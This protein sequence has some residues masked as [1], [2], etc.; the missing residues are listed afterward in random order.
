MMYRFGELELDTGRRELCR[1]GKPVKLTKLSFKVL[2]VLVESAPDLVTH[3]DLIDRVWGENRVISPENLSQRIKMLRESLGDSADTPTYIEVVRGQGVRLIP[4]VDDGPAVDSDSVSPAAQAQG[5]RQVASRA[6]LGLVAAIVAI[7]AL[8]WFSRESGYQRTPD[9]NVAGDYSSVAVLPFSNLSPDPNNSFFAAGMHEE[10][11]NQLAKLTSL[12]VISRTSMLRYQDTRESIPAIARQLDVDSII[13]GSVRYADERI[14]VTIQLVDGESDEHVWS[15]TYDR[16]FNNVFE[17]ESEV[18]RDVAAALHQVVSD[19]DVARL[20]RPPT[21]NLDAYAH[22]VKG[23]QLVINRKPAELHKAVEHFESAVEL[24]ADF[25]L[26][27]VGLA[28]SLSWLTTYAGLPPTQLFERR[29]AAIDSAMSINPSLAAAWL[30]FAGLR[31]DQG[32]YK[33]AEKYFRRSIELDPKSAQTYHQFGWFLNM[34]LGRSEESLPLLR[35]AVELDP[36]NPA[37]TGALAQALW[38]LGRPEEALAIKRELLDRDTDAVGLVSRQYS[39]LLA[40]LGRLDEAMYWAAIGAREDHN[41]FSSRSVECGATLN[42]GDDE[43]LDTCM[44]AISEDFP[45]IAEIERWS[46]LYIYRGQFELLLEQ[47]QALVEREPSDGSRAE[48]GFAYLLNGNIEQAYRI[49]QTLIPQYFS[50]ENVTLRPWD[51]PGATVTGIILLLAGETERANYL[52][53]EVLERTET[54]H[55]TRGRGYG[56]IDV[57]VHVARDEREKAIAA[58]RDAI[59]VGWRQEWWRL[60]GPGFERIEQE[61][62]WQALMA[63]LEADIAR[64]RANYHAYKNDPSHW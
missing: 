21:D 25:A 57:I 38:A 20:A 35:K 26:A 15:E 10:V 16:P 64:Q 5:T 19:K 61:P 7:V 36:V 18:A 48:L 42:I 9:E 47:M 2:E 33:E 34:R 14:R 13:E 45:A 46:G 29:Q 50:D 30:S 44:T 63:E 6:W 51:L 59:N 53:D 28:D 62:Q 55:R 31:S 12:R 56:V 52:F 37:P 17:I 32:E 3:D 54:L 60:R 22:Y 4:P 49:Y 27:W 8:L 39:I 23:Q 58:L 24:D 41:T 11:L 1:S 43:A 40:T